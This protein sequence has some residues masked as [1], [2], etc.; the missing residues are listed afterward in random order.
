MGIIPTAGKRNFVFQSSMYSALPTNVMR[1]GRTAGSMNESI[2]DVWFGQ[3]SAPPV[4]G[5]FSRPD[6]F[7]RQ[8]KR[9]A[10]PMMAFATG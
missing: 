6:A 7:M 8:R 2:T 4:S 9:N 3:M 5:T 10:G 1:R